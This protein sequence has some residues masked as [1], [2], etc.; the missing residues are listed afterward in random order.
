MYVTNK[1]VSKSVH[2]LSA[3]IFTDSLRVRCLS[4]NYSKIV[5][6]GSFSGLTILCI[7][8]SL[9]LITKSL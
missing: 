4:F 9:C 8:S 1:S 2:A 3:R 6:I 7:I 5:R